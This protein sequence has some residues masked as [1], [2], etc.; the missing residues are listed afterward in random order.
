MNGVPD[1]NVG[2]LG[3]SSSSFDRYAAV[4]MTDQAVSKMFNE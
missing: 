4:S 2:K 1:L 3:N